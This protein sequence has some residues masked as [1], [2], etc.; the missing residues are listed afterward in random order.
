MFSSTKPAT[1]G[2]TSFFDGLPTSVRDE[3]LS[4]IEASRATTR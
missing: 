2:T 4:A 1:A 3:V